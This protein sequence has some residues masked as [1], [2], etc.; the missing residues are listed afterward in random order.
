MKAYTHRIGAILYILW[1]II[2]VLGGGMMIVA[3][4]SGVNG[5]IALQTQSEQPILVDS[6]ADQN[7]AG[8]KAAK[9]VFTYPAGPGWRPCATR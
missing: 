7:S 5:L 3:A 9:G 8:F 1:G 6:S 2:Q 4:N